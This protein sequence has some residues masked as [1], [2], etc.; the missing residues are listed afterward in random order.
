MLSST[1]GCTKP[2]KILKEHDVNK[3]VST[4]TLVSAFVIATIAVGHTQGLLLDYAAERVAE[5]YK[6]STCEQ[7]KQMKSEGPSLKEKAAIAYLHSDDQ[8][9]IAFINKIAAPVAN[10]MFECDMFP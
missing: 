7:L 1:A 10:K 6:T 3:T 2:S 9:R 5:K 4:V 8:A